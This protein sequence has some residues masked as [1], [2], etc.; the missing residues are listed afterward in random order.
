[1][2]AR[3]I[4]P[5]VLQAAQGF[6]VVTLTGPRQSGKSTLCRA[7]FADKPY[8]NL[9]EPDTRAFATEDPR[10]FL[11][12]FP[13]GAVLDEVQNCPDLPSY[14]QPTVD[15]DPAPGRW[16]ITGSHNLSLIQTVSQS[17][18]GRTAVLNL[19]PLSYPEVMR[20]DKH[21]ATLNEVL[22]TGGY[23]RILDRALA[24]RE[25]LGPYVQTY[26]ERDVRTL[27]N[28]GDLATFQRFIQMC[29]GRTGQLLNLS[30]LASDVGVSQPT[31]RSW[32]LI[33]E[34]T[35]I[36]FRLQPWH[37]NIGKRLTKTPKL[38]FY[39]TGLA[40]WLLGI[41]SADQLQAHPLR[42]AIFETWIVTEILKHRVNRG[43]Q[44]G[45]F[46]YRDALHGEADALIEHVGSMTLIEAK[47]AQTVTDDLLKGVRA[48][49]ARLSRSAKPVSIVVFGGDRQQSR[50]DLSVIPWRALHDQPLL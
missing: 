37:G 16:I 20:F 35:F 31:I 5:R 36:A 3:D 1:M 7:L 49:A 29:A 50:P 4:E 28:I 24:P 42:G 47:A 27:A 45:L 48:V 10:G 6:P 33:L 22:V 13:T 30:A 39:D 18:A 26:L 38:H 12:Q 11:N 46:F 8:A 44:S 43:E 32:L 17:L 34:A 14:L 15:N 41:R 23:P 21:P 9:E 40:C 2:V 25:W 19:L